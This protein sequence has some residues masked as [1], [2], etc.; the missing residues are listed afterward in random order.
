VPLA[1]VTMSL[2]QVATLRMMPA[3]RGRSS[4]E[5]LTADEGVLRECRPQ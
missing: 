2:I 5:G 1:A 3:T 4:F